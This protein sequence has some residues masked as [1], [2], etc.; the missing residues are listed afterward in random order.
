MIHTHKKNSSNY[1]RFLLQSDFYKNLVPILVYKNFWCQELTNQMQPYYVM[2]PLRCSSV[3]Y[4]WFRTGLSHRR[5]VVVLAVVISFY[6]TIWGKRDQCPWLNSHVLHVLKIL[7]A[8]QLK[9]SDLEG[10]HQSHQYEHGDREILSPNPDLM[11][12]KL[13]KGIPGICIF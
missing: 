6:L 7:V 9:I 8:H 13:F 10:T 2:R 1:P 11:N 12:Q 4:L 3:L 5:A